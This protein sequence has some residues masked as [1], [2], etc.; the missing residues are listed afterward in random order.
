[1]NL[2]LDLYA[3]LDLLSSGSAALKPSAV[4]TDVQD[5]AV[6]TRQP[7]TA[8]FGGES[9]PVV[10]L[11]PTDD[12]DL[13]PTGWTWGITVN[14]AGA[15]AAY[16]FFLPAG[17]TDFTA[18]DAT[19]C[20][21]TFTPT[22]DLT[23]LPNGTGVRLSGDSLPAGF[24]A[25]TTYYVVSASDDTFELAATSGGDPIAS[26]GAGSGSVTVAQWNLSALTPVSSTTMMT[27][28]LPLPSGTPSSGEVPVATGD[29]NAT[30]WGSPSGD[31]DVSSVTAAD[32]SIVVG[33]TGDDPTVRLATPV[34][35]GRGGTGAATAAQNSVFAGPSTG[36][37]GAPSFRSLAAA[38]VPTLNQA[39]TGNAATATAAAGLKSATTTVVVSAAT[40]PSE[41]QVLTATSSTAADWETPSS[42]FADPMTTVG[43][44]I[45]EG[46]GPE[47]ARL[48]GN[49][50]TTKLFLTQTG[51]GSA[52]AAPAWGTIASGD[53]PTLNQS[54]T[55]NAATA[56]NLAGGAAFPAYV[57]PK[58]TALT[59]GSSV[60]LNAALGNEFSWTLGAGSHTLAA[61][62]NPVDGQAIRIRVKY[63]GSFTPEFNA[64][65]DFGAAGAPAW[66]A[67]SGKTD[68]VAFVYD[69]ALND[70]AGSWYYAGAALGFTS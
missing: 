67:A 31:G 16:S 22:D 1:V 27:P 8:S 58:V 33:G 70:A 42:G 25:A 36:G 44:V 21:F 55:G 51:T 24:E 37:T 45:Y 54:T 11:I 3:G 17:P 9:A 38:D 28:Y 2:V 63:S 47:P 12:P 46:A 40:A 26:T 60:A 53:V 49:T 13:S 61:P 59:D 65:F 10:A 6:V 69:A 52:S 14:A 39:T 5:Q 7:V 23:E 66:S 35:V 20:V 41:G 56:T 30:A 64:V 48:A 19:P 43:D 29:G 18:T 4:L 62:S 32:S 50:S 68:V 57:A 15:P 34:T